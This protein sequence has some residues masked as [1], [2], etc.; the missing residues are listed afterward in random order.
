MSID[1][2]IETVFLECTR[3]IEA[4][5]LIQR[6][7]SSDKEFS[8]Q[9][10]FANR[11]AAIGLTFDQPSRNRYPDFQLVDYPIGFEIK[12]LGFPGREANYDCN[13]QVPRGLHQDRTIYY[14]FGRYPAQVPDRQYPVYDLVMCHG[15]FLN[16]DHTYSHH[17]KNLK[18]FGSYGDLI[19]RDRKMYVAPTPFAL[20]NGTARQITLLVPA[21]FQAST[22]LRPCGSLVRIETQHLL[23]GYYFDM[24]EQT[25]TPSYIENP[26]AGKQHHFQAFRAVNTSGPLI[27][28]NS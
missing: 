11:L 9:N 22:A 1:R 7:S 26:N 12:G 8:F 23:R 21:A 16:A 25:L 10:W 18:G 3:A 24:T 15:D 19:V 4:S 14:V 20:L 17:N 28:L 5:E 6:V 2:C 27:T 13:S